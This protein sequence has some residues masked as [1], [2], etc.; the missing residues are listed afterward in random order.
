MGIFFPFSSLLSCITSFGDFLLT[1]Y[2]LDTQAQMTGMA[3]VLGVK[4]GVRVC[5]SL[6]PYI[7]IFDL[8]PICLQF[9]AC[10]LWL[11][12]C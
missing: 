1:S 5:H 3:V 9:L 7:G 8:E 6:N 2:H 4:V 12:W 10:W 11:L